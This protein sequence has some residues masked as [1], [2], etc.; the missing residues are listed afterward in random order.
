M[1]AGPSADCSTVVYDLVE[2]VGYIS[3]DGQQT[4]PNAACCSG[5]QSVIKVDVMCLCAAMKLSASMGIQLNL[6]RAKSLPADCGAKGVSTTLC[7]SNSTSPSGSPAGAPVAAPTTPATPA[8]P[9]PAPAAPA[10]SV[11]SAPSPK[12]S[13]APPAPAAAAAAPEASPA[14]AGGVDAADAPAPA[15]VKA[16]AYAISTSVSLVLGMVF[17]SLYLIAM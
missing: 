9:A 12:A 16:G 7:D 11:P 6:T 10:P 2:C 3:K 1:A 15:P 4:K 5:L 13:P 8:A 17:V 14:D